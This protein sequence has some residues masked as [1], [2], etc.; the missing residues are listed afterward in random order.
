MTWHHFL[1]QMILVKARKIGVQ[2]LQDS[3]NKMDLLD[4]D[5]IIMYSYREVESE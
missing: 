2:V 4:V 1:D 3:M 5:I